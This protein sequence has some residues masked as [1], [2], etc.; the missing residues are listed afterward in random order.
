MRISD[1]SSDVCSSDLFGTRVP[2]A[3]RRAVAMALLALS[4]GIAVVHAPARLF[5]RMAQRRPLHG[6]RAQ[7]VPRS[8]A[9][10]RIDADIRD[11][12]DIDPVAQPGKG[13]LAAEGRVARRTEEHTSEL[14]SPMRT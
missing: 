13:R 9:D 14:Q 8:A 4:P 2:P 5:E 6:A 12:E 1:W 10:H 7:P 11:I 3:A